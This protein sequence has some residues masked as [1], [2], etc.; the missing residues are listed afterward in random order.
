M[1][2]PAAPGSEI[3][4]SSISPPPPDAAASLLVAAFQ[5]R[6]QGSSSVSS[7]TRND[8]IH[9]QHSLSITT[10]TCNKPEIIKNHFQDEK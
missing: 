8:H 9:S 5:S 4:S 3:S 1:I 6:S 7:V 2:V 10:L